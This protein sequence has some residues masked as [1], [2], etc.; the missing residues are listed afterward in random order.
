MANTVMALLVAAAEEGGHIAR[1]L[2][3]HPYVFGVT[4]LAFFATAL[5]VTWAFKGMAHG[6]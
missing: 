6:H 5:A 2:P 4:A 1:E 3:V